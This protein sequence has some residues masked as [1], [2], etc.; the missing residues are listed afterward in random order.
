MSK[1]TNITIDEARELV[2]DDVLWPRVRDFLWNF[3]PQV[4]ESWLEGL[5]PPALAACGGGESSAPNPA[6]LADMPRVRRFF[7]SS[8]GVEPAFHAF[9]KGDMSRILLL[10]GG[11]VLEIA[12]W[13]GALVLARRL[14]LVTG[15]AAVREL[16]AALPGVYP[17]VFGF[18]AY[19]RGLEP[20]F[21]EAFPPDGAKR[22]ADAE[23]VVSAGLSVLDSLLADIPRPVASRLRFKLPKGICDRE[24]AR[25]DPETC[26]KALARLLKLK[27]PEAY[28]LCC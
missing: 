26:G 21:A 24:P 9:P 20:S 3:A 4:H 17:E 23:G 18:T 14:R 10:D 19:F 12:K 8:L 5:Q 7:L 27:F 15:G 22:P 11:I 6:R 16:K 13:L 1:Q 28:S 25:L 2:G